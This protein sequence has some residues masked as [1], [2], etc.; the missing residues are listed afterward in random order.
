[1]NPDNIELKEQLERIEVNFFCQ[2]QFLSQ[3]QIPQLVTK[4][5]GGDDNFKYEDSYLE[6]IK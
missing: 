6:T 1:M 5:F 2:L 3:P 4:G